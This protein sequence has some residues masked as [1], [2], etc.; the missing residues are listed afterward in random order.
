MNA[1]IYSFIHSADSVCAGFLIP[2]ALSK[3]QEVSANPSR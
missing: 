2:Q 1:L 3:R